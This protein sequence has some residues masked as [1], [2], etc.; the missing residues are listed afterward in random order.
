MQ[1][2]TRLE[3]GG[4]QPPLALAVVGSVR[5]DQRS[6][7]RTSTCVVDAG[8]AVVDWGH[9]RQYG[10]AEAQRQ[11]EAQ[12]DHNAR[13]RGGKNSAEVR[14]PCPD[15]DHEILCRY[16]QGGYT[17]KVLAAEVGCSIWR[18]RDA[19]K[20]AG[21]HWERRPRKQAKRKAASTSP[22]YEALGRAGGVE[23]GRQRREVLKLFDREVRC[24]HQRGLSERGIAHTLTR[25]G[26]FGHVG[27]KKVRG[28]L[29]RVRSR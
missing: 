15:L 27:R 6:P 2:K 13:S 25:R 24:L 19:I 9:V 5:R 28:A 22:D 18:V 10:R 12:K 11:R 8:V 29:N 21:M 3:K 14:A 23:S 17:Q 20:R 1:E 4:R 16:E 26:Q 7:G